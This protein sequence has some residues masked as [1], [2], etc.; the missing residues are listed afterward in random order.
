M[1]VAHL[2][3]YAQTN[4]SFVS[5]IGTTNIVP[6]NGYAVG[7]GFTGGCMAEFPF[8]GRLFL[9]TGLFFSEKGAFCPY[10]NSHDM[11]ISSY[12]RENVSYLESPIQLQCLLFRQLKVQAGIYN[13]VRLNLLPD[14]NGNYASSFVQYNNRH[15]FGYAAGLHFNYKNL[16]L[17]A[18]FLKSILP[19]ALNAR[20]ILPDVD[21]IIDNT[22]F[23]N[24]NLFFVFGYKIWGSQKPEK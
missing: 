17:E 6:G 13:A 11:S 23:Y 20:D 8:T 9:K 1:L 14:D 12:R 24:Q 22:K 2:T 4:V 18:N 21:I 3:M 16:V 5:G 7:L 10:Y 19:I 15:D